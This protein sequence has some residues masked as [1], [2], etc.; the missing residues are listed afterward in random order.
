MTSKVL[1]QWSAI[2]YKN[3]MVIANCLSYI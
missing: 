3:I 1:W 2:N